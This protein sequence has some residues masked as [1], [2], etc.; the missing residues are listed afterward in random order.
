MRGRVV[1]NKQIIYGGNFNG[2]V[3]ERRISLPITF[4]KCESTLDSG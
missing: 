1:Y 3:S 2:T 4:A